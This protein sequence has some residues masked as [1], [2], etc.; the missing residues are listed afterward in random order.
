MSIKSPTAQPFVV[1]GNVS[2]VPLPVVAQQQQ[3]SG[4]GIRIND[5]VDN[6][7]IC[8]SLVLSVSGKD[9]LLWHVLRTVSFMFRSSGEDSN[10]D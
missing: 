4:L 7:K 5:D 8:K 3:P 1:L 2:F 10:F 6:S 9:C